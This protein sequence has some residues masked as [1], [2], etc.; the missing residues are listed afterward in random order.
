[1]KRVLLLTL[2]AACQRSTPGDGPAPA[3]SPA[4]VLGASPGPAGSTRPAVSA[5]AVPAVSAPVAPGPDLLPSIT[6]RCCRLDHTTG[7]FGP[8]TGVNVHY[9]GDVVRRMDGGELLFPHDLISDTRELYV[10][11]KS[12]GRSLSQERKVRIVGEQGSLVSVVIEDHGDTGAG[13]PFFHSRCS[14]LDTRKLKSVA[15]TDAV[16]A[17]EARELLAEGQRRFDAAPGHERYRLVPASFA[18]RGASNDVVFCCPAR[19]DTQASSRL[20]LVV[21]RAAS[22]K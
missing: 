13:T 16:P 9:E 2:L 20:D 17:D 19:D 4:A 21:P 7:G 1:M 10:F 5:S 11:A 12:A 3:A 22:A 15:L 8:A 18:L 6:A 14:T